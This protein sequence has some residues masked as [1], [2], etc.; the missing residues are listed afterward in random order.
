MTAHKV[1]KREYPMPHEL[2]VAIH[3][4]C[5]ALKDN[6]YSGGAVYVNT[7]NMLDNV[8]LFWHDHNDMLRGCLVDLEHGAW[9]EYDW[10]VDNAEQSV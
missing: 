3:G 2:D 8:H 6:G 1:I 9:R 7:A 4:L 5:K 10:R